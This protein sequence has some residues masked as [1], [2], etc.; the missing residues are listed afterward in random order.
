MKPKIA[1][2][3]AAGAL[4]VAACGG[5]DEPELPQLSQATGASLGACAALASFTYANTTV[6]SATVVGAG[7]LTVARMPI[8]SH[9]RVTGTM[10]QRTSAPTSSSG[11]TKRADPSEL[12]KRPEARVARASTPG[13][14]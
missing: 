10:F 6:A 9:C 13:A 2:G 7:T 3:L 1:L 14:P 11:Y 8:P 4:L 12:T 5:S